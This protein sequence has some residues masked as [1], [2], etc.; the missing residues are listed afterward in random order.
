M[1]LQRLNKKAYTA[2]V[3]GVGV[4]E[5]EPTTKVIN[6]TRTIWNF[7]KPAWNVTL[8]A[9]WEPWM[10]TTAAFLKP[11]LQCL[12]WCTGVHKATTTSVSAILTSTYLCVSHFTLRAYQDSTSAASTL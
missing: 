9:W 1:H 7:Q 4:G 5:V 2:V 6:T 10:T 3:S 8:V 12:C 11:M